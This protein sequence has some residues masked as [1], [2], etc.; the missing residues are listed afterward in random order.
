M[1]EELK[2][3]IQDKNLII[4]TGRII[5]S[6]RAGKLKKVFLSKNC[7]LGIKNDIRHYA[8]LGKIDIF[9]L[10]ISNEEIGVMCKKPFSIS[11]LGC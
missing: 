1:K 10:S 11:V 2:D 3:A 4:G 7:P 8:K 6:L 9:E 5:K